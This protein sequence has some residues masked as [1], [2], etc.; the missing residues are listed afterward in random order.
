[1]N[2]SNHLRCAVSSL[3]KG[4]AG[5]GSAMTAKDR[6]QFLFGVLVEYDGRDQ[7]G[8]WAG[9]TWAPIFVTC[10]SSRDGELS[11]PDIDYNLIPS[12]SPE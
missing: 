4:K 12:G 1:M 11:P 7:R 5:L 10:S 3:M 9:S 8:R 2:A 6:L